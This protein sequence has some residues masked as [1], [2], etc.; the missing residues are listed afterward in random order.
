MEGMIDNLIGAYESGRLSRRALV[1][2][3]AGLAFA[4]SS[5]QAAAGGFEG[6]SLNHVNI[7]SRDLEKSVEFY[8]RIFKLPVIM[9]AADTVQLGIG[10][11]Q[12]LSLQRSKGRTGM[13]HF[14]IGI[15]RFNAQTVIA[16][17][18]ARGAMP[19]GQGN[20]HVIDPDGVDVQLIGNQ[21]A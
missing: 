20:L 19:T 15:D 9:R 10:K 11:G 7:A 4:S 5:A 2:V 12:H 13:D 6:N 17:L 18:R 16:D 3:L 1:G 14:A 21:A 8:Q